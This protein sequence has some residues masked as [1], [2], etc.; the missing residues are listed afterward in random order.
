MFDKTVISTI[1]DKCG[2]KLKILFKEE[3]SIEL[4]KIIGLINNIDKY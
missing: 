1:C 3:E 2:S 4:C